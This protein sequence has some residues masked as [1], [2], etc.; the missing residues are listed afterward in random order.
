MNTALLRRA[1][2]LWASGDRRTDRHNQRAWVRS[3][4]S[5]GDKWLLAQP[6]RRITP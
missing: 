2:I 6:V 5:L 4:R 3:I 1:R